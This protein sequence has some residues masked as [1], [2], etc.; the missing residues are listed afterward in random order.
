[1][2]TTH[3]SPA[4]TSVLLAFAE[5]NRLERARAEF[6]AAK[7]DAR[8]KLVRQADQID[9]LRARF[10]TERPRAW[11]RVHRAS[12][13]A[14]RLRERAAA[15][16]LAA[17]EVAHR[18]RLVRYEAELDAKRL[19]L[20]ALESNPVVERPSRRVL[21]W[22]MPAAATA[23]VAFLGFTFLGEDAAE[24]AH[25]TTMIDADVVQME[26]IF[27]PIVP[28]AEAEAEAPTPAPVASAEPKASM[29][30]ASKPEANKPKANKP[31]EVKKHSN[32]LIIGDFDGNPLG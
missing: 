24:A 20:A 27:A 6:A 7:D 3:A 31:A 10:E 21:E 17:A 32:P 5:L 29:P 12:A 25:R 28:L 23:L 11:S 16:A 14:R 18:E 9:E 19:R 26:P 30:K 1:M 15:E 4:E 22:S 8:A 2:T 13:D